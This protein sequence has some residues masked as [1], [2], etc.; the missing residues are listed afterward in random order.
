MNGLCLHNAINPCFVSPIA[1]PSIVIAV[2][3]Y[4]GK[5]FSSAYLLKTAKISSPLVGLTKSRILRNS[6]FVVKLLKTIIVIFT[7]N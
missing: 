2:N 1:T 7:V 6:S 3:F 4:N 5:L